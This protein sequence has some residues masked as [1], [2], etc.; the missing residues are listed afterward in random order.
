MGEPLQ[1]AGEAD[2]PIEVT[3]PIRHATGDLRWCWERGRAVDADDGTV[4]LEG[5]VT[6][7]TKR[8]RREQELKA[9]REFTE[10]ALNVLDDVF[11]VVDPDSEQLLRWNDR[12]PETLGYSDDQLETMEVPDLIADDHLGQAR[13]GMA[14]AVSENS[15]TVRADLVTSDGQRLPHEFRGRA[16]HDDDEGGL[17][18]IAGVGRD[19]GDHIHRQRELERFETVVQA[20]GDPVYALDEDGVLTFANDAIE[21]MTG[22][23][24]ETLVGSHV[25]LILPDADVASGREQIERMLKDSQHRAQKFEVDVKTAAGDCIPSELHIALLPMDDGEF[26]GTAGI[27]RD[28]TERKHREERLEQFA[29]V[30]SHDLRNPLNVIQGHI[31]VMQEDIDDQRVAAIAT[32]ADRMAELIDDLLTLAQQG[33]SVG[34]TETVPLE[35]VAE[36]AWSSVDAPGATLD[37]WTTET[38]DADPERLRDLFENL[39]RN[40]VEHGSDAAHVSVGSLGDGAAFFIADDGPGIPE[41]ERGEVFEHGYTTDE[42]GTGFGLS[43]VERIAK[44]HDWTVEVTESEAGGA[45]FEF[46]TG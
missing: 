35:M 5:L 15:A 18:G 29:G 10:D 8:N 36:R 13:E 11:F 37:R 26:R 40:A 39:F 22:Y 34:E 32:A 42:Q 6:D 17:L 30:V 16:L 21:E 31:G 38:V 43:I 24:V 20:V 2:E 46:Y 27:I 9:Q 33:D 14:N 45:R 23:E 25:D 44:A 41:S 12:L 28:I 4:T 1:H 19:I 7:I 3:Y